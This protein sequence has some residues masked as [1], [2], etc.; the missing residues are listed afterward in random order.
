MTSEVKFDIL[1]NE[2]FLK[3]SLCLPNMRE[4]KCQSQ[5]RKCSQIR[6]LR[7]NTK[8]LNNLDLSTTVS[9]RVVIRLFGSEA[10]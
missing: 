7:S 4:K 10:V 1:H 6:T 9:Y 5:V 3:I 8:V 2:N